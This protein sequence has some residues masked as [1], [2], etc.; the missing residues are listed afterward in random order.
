M[1]AS[2]EFTLEYQ[3]GADNGV[4]DALSGIPICHNHK[5]VWSLLE[6]VIMGAVDKGEAEVSEKLLGKHEHL[7][8][9]A[10]V[11]AARMV[12]MHIVDWGEAQEA[13]PMLA[14]CRRWLCT[15]KDTQFLKRDALLR[16]YSGEN[17]NTST[18]TTASS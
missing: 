9:E 15:H 4:A 14:A 1:L 18:C 2:F 16:K 6:G 5:T 3:K 7:G 8:N 10:H 11:Q 17:V 13:D 12:P